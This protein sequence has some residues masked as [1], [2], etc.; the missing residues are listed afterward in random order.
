MFSGKTL[1]K[2]LSANLAVSALLVSLIT[3]LACN[4][5]TNPATAPAN[6]TP[7][8]MRTVNS[9]RPFESVDGTVNLVYE[10]VV[11]NFGSG[12]AKIVEF[13]AFDQDH[14]TLLNLNTTQLR[15]AFSQVGKPRTVDTVL[16]S[17]ESAI[18]WVNVAL[19]NTD[20]APTE[21]SHRIAYQGLVGDPEIHGELGGK[22]SVDNKPPV[23][24][25]APLTGSNWIAMN[26]YGVRSPHRRALFP[27]S[28]DLHSTQR[29]A[30]D[31]IK[32]DDK[33]IGLN[34]PAANVKSYPAYGQTIHAVSD[35]V[36]VGVVEKFPDQVP[37]QPS[38]NK[39]FPGG[40]TITMAM[41]DGTFA[42]YAH[43]KPGSIRVKEGDRVT[44]G[45][46]LGLVGN[47]GNSSEPHL[48]FHVSETADILASNSIPYVIDDFVVEGE[49]M[50]D[51]KFDM[52]KAKG[53]PISVGKPYY[54]GQHHDHMPKEGS[55]ITFPK[56]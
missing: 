3:G 34:G 33:K 32:L 53:L 30:I 19:K 22:L 13:Q 26:C 37:P 4:A 20:N 45:Q 8:L 1:T 17:G 23:H 56:Q 18:I 25:S 21:L 35:G 11:T 38:G 54:S 24:I 43:I 39:Y 6:W 49:I 9:P 36:I 51:R 16:Q 46:V 50:D 55:V 41:P 44:R 52:E 29:N 15:R 14:K 27:V 28:G 10:I 31:W 5:E 42:F 12:P 40:N 47:A 2:R 48:H 7:L